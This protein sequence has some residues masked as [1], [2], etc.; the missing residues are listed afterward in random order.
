MLKLVE[1][2]LQIG[3]NSV[4]EIPVDALT[5]MGIHTEDTIKLIYM[6]ESEENLVN[7]TREFVLTRENAEDALQQE[8]QIAFQI[9]EALLADAGIPV[10]AD[11]E[12]VCADGKIMILPSGSEHSDEKMPEELVGII[13][14]LGIPRD[15]VQVVL[16]TEGGKADGKTNL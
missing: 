8:E 14:E 13:N 5:Q 3:K 4:I 10:D 15:R 11:L 9:P 6:A 7:A 1:L 2:A 12:I 16:H